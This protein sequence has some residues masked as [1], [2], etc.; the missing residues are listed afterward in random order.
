M[1]SRIRPGGVFDLG[2]AGYTE[3]ALEDAMPAFQ[4]VAV[5][6]ATLFAG[7]AIYVTVAEIRHGWNVAQG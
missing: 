1:R 3:R 5:L 7:A 6:A 2:A 4:F